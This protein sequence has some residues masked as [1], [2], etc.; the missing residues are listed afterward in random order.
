MS[1][2]YDIVFDPEIPKD[3]R[4]YLTR[5]YECHNNVVYLPDYFHFWLKE[6]D[7][8]YSLKNEYFCSIVDKTIRNFYWII[9]EKESDAILFKLTWY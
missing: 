1:G 6:L 2:N 8:S 4:P 7:I 9:F 5:F 3:N